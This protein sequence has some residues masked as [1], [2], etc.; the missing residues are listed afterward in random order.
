VDEKVA[1]VGG[2]ALNSGVVQYVEEE[3]GLKLA[4]LQADPRIF[5]AFGAALMAKEKH[6]SK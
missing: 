5:G 2:V 4:E 3:L 6:M 1:M